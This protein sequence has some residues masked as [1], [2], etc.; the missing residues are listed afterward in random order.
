MLLITEGGYGK[1]TEMESFTAKHRGGQGV[2]AM[3]LSGD[4]G[5]LVA[6]RAVA[7][8]EEVL[9]VS[10]NGVVIRIPVDDI[11]I[12]GPYATGVKV[13]SLGR[14][15]RVAAVA[16]VLQTDDGDPSGDGDSGGAVGGDEDGAERIIDAS[17]T[18]EPPATDQ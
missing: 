8:G 11:S 9:L 2:T 5:K 10:S 1:R 17:G 12:Q 18:V 7:P 13:M 4:K 6:S 3:K 16:P 14:E 15:E